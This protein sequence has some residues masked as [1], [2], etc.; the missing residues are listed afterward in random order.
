MKEIELIC[1]ALQ[2]A[3]VVCDWIL[4]YERRG[5][6]HAD[7]EDGVLVAVPHYKDFP[8]WLWLK[9]NSAGR[10]WKGEAQLNMERTE[11]LVHVLLN[12]CKIPG[13]NAFM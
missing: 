2:Q 12:I 11:K 13:Y 7:V 10:V 1:L 5:L 3:R 8:F 6:C 4:G 9:K